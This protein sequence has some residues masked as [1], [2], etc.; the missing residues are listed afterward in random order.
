[1]FPDDTVYNEHHDKLLIV[2]SSKTTLMPL[3][4]QA[5]N[6]LSKNDTVL[7]TI[8]VIHYF[9][10]YND[11]HYKIGMIDIPPYEKNGKYVSYEPGRRMS[12]SDVSN[13]ED[14]NVN[15]ICDKAI[16]ITDCSNYYLYL[17]LLYW[18][19]TLVLVY[20]FMRNK[21]S[22]PKTKSKFAR[23][24]TVLLRPLKI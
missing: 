13:T 6:Y 24:K 23:M 17:Y 16:P 2:Q 4:N 10:M 1:V 11:L 18:I 21:G 15:I 7:N 3:I 9:L 19:I 12:F 14:I 8:S 5:S 22:V 20:I